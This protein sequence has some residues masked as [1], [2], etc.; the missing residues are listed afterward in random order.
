MSSFRPTKQIGVGGLELGAPERKY[1]DEVIASNRLS[2]GP[3]TARFER[4]FAELHDC[5]YS[6]FCNS[7]TSAL[8]IALAALKERHGW[9]NG[10][11]VIV[12]ALT[13]VA[14]SNIVLHNGM[15]PVFVDVERDTYNLDPRLLEEKIT[16]RTRAIIPVHLFGLPCDMDPILEVARRHDLRVIEDSCETMFAGY[17]GRK[18][19]SLGDIGCFSTYI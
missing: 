11:E 17:K 16:P 14:T 1:L 19:G 4:D 13:F 15:V 8:H 2:Y 7:G 5:R 9:A 3:M 10:D 6:V 12:P 18:V